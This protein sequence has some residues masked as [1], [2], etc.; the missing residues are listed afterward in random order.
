M[1]EEQYA[2]IKGQLMAN[3]KEHQSYNRRLQDHDEHLNKLDNTYVMLE[4]LTNSVNSLTAGMG[5]LK[6]AVQ[7][8][9]KR[10]AD[11]E[12]EPADKWKKATWKIIELVLA[13]VVGA[14]LVYFTK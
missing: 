9:D 8:V 12:R 7:S 5:D 10:V 3:D 4:R 13:A 11:I 1:N 6:A 2:E 14:A